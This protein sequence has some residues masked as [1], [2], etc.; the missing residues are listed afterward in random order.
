MASD[1]FRE[2]KTQRCPVLFPF[3]LRVLS[4]EIILP[5]GLRNA[6]PLSAG[7]RELN[8]LLKINAS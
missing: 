5:G 6:I 8:R 7:Q 3:T 4:Q 1:A 2:I